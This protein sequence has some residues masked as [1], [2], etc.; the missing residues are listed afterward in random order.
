MF[1]GDILAELVFGSLYGALVTGVALVAAIP[2]GLW[3]AIKWVG[4]RVT[5]GEHGDA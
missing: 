2:Y 4:Q 5:G 3:Q 1:V